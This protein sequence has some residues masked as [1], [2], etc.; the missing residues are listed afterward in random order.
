MKYTEKRTVE[1]DQHR[2]LACGLGVD[3]DEYLQLQGVSDTETAKFRGTHISEETI[4]A[5]RSGDRIFG[6]RR[7]ACWTELP[8]RKYISK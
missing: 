4:F 1:V 8:H 6:A 3:G 2:E 5:R 7:N